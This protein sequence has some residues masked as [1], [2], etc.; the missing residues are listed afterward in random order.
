[1]IKKRVF[2]ILLI[3]DLAPW[4]TGTIA[5]QISYN[6]SLGKTSI[7]QSIDIPKNKKYF[8]K[9]LNNFDLI[10]W[11]VPYDYEKYGN[12]VNKPTITHLHHV[13]EW[14]KSLSIIKSD[15]IIVHS[16]EWK[17]FLL[18]R[19]VNEKKIHY[20]SYGVSTE[21]FKPLNRF[22]L[23][24]KFHI[25]DEI[26]LVGFFG[27]ASSS[28]QERK[29]IDI[30]INSLKIVRKKIGNLGVLITGPG[31]EPIKNILL[32]YDIKVF[33]KI[34]PLYKDMVKM[35]NL[36]DC[37]L[38]T[39]RVEGG[40]ITLLESMS[41]GIPVI[42]TPVG[43]AK[44]IIKDG[45]NGLLINKDD[46]KGAAEALISLATNKNLRNKL[47]ENGR[48]LMVENF[49]WNKVLK[50]F[51]NVY[52]KAMENWIISNEKHSNLKDQLFYYTKL[53][54][55]YKFLLKN[56]NLVTKKDVY[57]INYNAKEDNI[58]DLL[59]WLEY[60]SIQKDKKTYLIIFKEILVKYPFEK[61]FW[62]Y[63]LKEF[64]RKLISLY[65]KFYNK[66]RFLKKFIIKNR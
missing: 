12:I 64:L 33:Y 14:R 11:F 59:S 55:E 7:Y 29:G 57:N 16:N 58:V 45:E 10:H 31:W 8:S 41:C 60:F 40:P 46:P 18:K 19:G 1:M 66:I 26:F 34:V 32:R 52:L 21:T 43:M 38:I 15:V 50:N 61:R 44:D 28:E 56:K 51:E 9:L 5:K 37:Y 3:P 27:K 23:K 4:V 47:K 48:K 20:I 17:E 35:Y 39:S 30:F 63:F 54:R 62:V 53:Y 24:R 25:P 13:I 65:N 2:S 6:L 49:P 22:N 42:T 36:L